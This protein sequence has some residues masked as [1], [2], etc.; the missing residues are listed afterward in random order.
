MATQINDRRPLPYGRIAAG[1]LNNSFYHVKSVVMIQ[2]LSF[3]EELIQETGKMPAI[4]LVTQFEPQINER[5]SIECRLKAM[6]EKAENRLLQQYSFRKALPVLAR[7]QDLMQ[8]ISYHTYKKSIALLAT[9]FVAKVLYLDFPVNETIRTGEDLDIRNVL[10]AKS[11]QS[12]YFVLVLLNGLAR[13]YEGMQDRLVLIKHNLLPGKGHLLQV[14]VGL[15]LVLEAMRLPVFVM[16]ERPLLEFYKKE[17]THAEQIMA[18]LPVD[19]GA[20]EKEFL[21]ILQ[22][23]L[24]NWQ[25]HQQALLLQKLNRAR[26]EGTLHSGIDQVWQAASHRRSALLAV[27]ENY[28]HYTQRPKGAGKKD[29]PQA[30]PLIDPLEQFDQ[31]NGT[32]EEVLKDG[33]EVE[34]MPAGSLRAFQQI[35]LVEAHHPPV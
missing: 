4:C 8:E 16:G 19:A 31:V 23:E 1:T 34:L 2:V 17:T 20:G 14:D 6:L 15:G 13:L 21:A 9:P 27:E 22:P 3:P 24:N 28:M 11:N 10:K 26:Q 35:A 32:I 12:H 5:S 18:Y 7:M 25:Q 30:W 29:E 33:G